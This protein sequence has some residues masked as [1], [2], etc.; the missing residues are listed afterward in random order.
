MWYDSQFVT[1]IYKSQFDDRT[2]HFG[3]F[4]KSSMKPTARVCL[5]TELLLSLYWWKMNRY[6]TILWGRLQKLANSVMIDGYSFVYFILGKKSTFTNFAPYAPPRHEPKS[7]VTKNNG[8][9]LHFII[10]TYFCVVFVS[11]T[12]YSVLV[13]NLSILLVI[14]LSVSCFIY[15]I[16]KL[17]IQTRGHNY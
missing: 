6:R 9:S 11:F 17:K 2:G 14:Q 10:W 12:E 1:G 8:C 13:L 15:W 7:S 5:G 4:S 3:N 16:V